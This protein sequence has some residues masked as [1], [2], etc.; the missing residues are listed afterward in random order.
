MPQHPKALVKERARRLRETGAAT[1]A[2][3]FET[4]IGR[5]KR[6]LVESGTLARADDYAPVTLASPAAPGSIVSV[7]I[8]GQDGE[9]LTGALL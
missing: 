1:R 9:R 5:V 3:F 4:Q 8:T 2:R 6:V 7:R